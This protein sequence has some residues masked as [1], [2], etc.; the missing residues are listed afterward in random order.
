MERQIRRHGEVVLRPVS[1]IPGNAKLVAAKNKLIVAHSESGHHHTLTASNGAAIGFL[2]YDGKTYL[3]IPFEAKLEHQKQ[4]LEI[5]QTQIVEPGL[6]ERI[7]KQSYSYRDK[8][9]KQVW[10]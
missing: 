1:Q 5:H 3:D 4:G 9:M 8:I 2:E 10:D 6:Y 7:I